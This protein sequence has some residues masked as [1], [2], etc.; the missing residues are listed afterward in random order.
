MKNGIKIACASDIHGNLPRDISKGNDILILAGD[1]SPATN[2]S[3]PFQEIWTEY[4]FLPWC[5]K[6]IKNSIAKDVV[7]I[8]G[9]HDF[10]GEELMQN[11][12]ENDFRNR[13]PEHVHYLRD[14]SVTLHGIN[15]YGTPFQP[16]FYDWAWNEDDNDE[17]IGKHFEKIQPCDILVSHGPCFGYN[18]TVEFRKTEH[19]GSK[20][21]LKHVHRVKPKLLIAGHLHSANHSI[22]KIM[23]D[24][25]TYT[26]SV[27]VSILDEGYQVFYNVFYNTFKK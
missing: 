11:G 18:D 1:L 14:S 2:H 23:H 24:D 21:L 12:K 25:G 27:V 19:L 22:E 6:Q 4:T 3:I 7:F 10:Y 15:I 20:I 13:L 9:N 16:R 17:C 8:F 26:E 5:E